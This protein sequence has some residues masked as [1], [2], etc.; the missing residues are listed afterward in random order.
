MILTRVEIINVLETS[1]EF[2]S[3]LGKT[4]KDLLKNGFFNETSNK[5]LINFTL[6]TNLNSFMT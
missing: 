2:L 3:M 1:L 5:Y 4:F 6:D